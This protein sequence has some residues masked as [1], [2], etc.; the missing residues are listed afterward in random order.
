M[1]IQS[2]N[3]VKSVSR[4]EFGEIGESEQAIIGK[5]EVRGYC[6]SAA[7]LDIVTASKVDRPIRALS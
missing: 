1:T 5:S 6:R 4:L 7:Q 3:L 2:P